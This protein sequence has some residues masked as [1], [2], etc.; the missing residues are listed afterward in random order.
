VKRRTLLQLAAGSAAAVSLPRLAV[1]AKLDELRLDY[2]YYSPTSL[3]V[4]RFG[5][6][7]HNHE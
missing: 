1:A 3:V 6:L 2:A 5:W 4:R 7:E